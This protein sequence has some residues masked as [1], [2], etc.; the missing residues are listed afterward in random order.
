[1]T[2]IHETAV[3]GVLSARITAVT[4]IQ[5]ITVEAVKNPN[6]IGATATMARRVNAAIADVPSKIRITEVISIPKIMRGIADGVPIKV[7]IAITPKEARVNTAKGDLS[8][9]SGEMK[10]V[11][12]QIG[13]AVL[14][15]SGTMKVPIIVR[16]TAQAG[17]LPA[18][19]M[20]NG[21]K[22][23]KAPHREAGTGTTM[24]MTPIAVRKTHEKVAPSL[25]SLELQRPFHFPDGD[26]YV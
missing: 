2:T 16:R 3:K 9:I 14:K 22:T 21:M 17:M 6:Q 18:P 8:T 4:N 20:S 25:C 23:R 13:A 7:K 10:I 19:N 1:M 26:G 12:A 15:K 5:M 11:P 24:M